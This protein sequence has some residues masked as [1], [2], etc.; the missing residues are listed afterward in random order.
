MLHK[1]IKGY[2]VVQHKFMPSDGLYWILANRRLGPETYEWLVAG[3]RHIDDDHW[4]TN[5][6]Y[7]IW[8]KDAIQ[9]FT[10][11]TTGF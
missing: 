3:L 9:R 4:V 8:Y 2:T 6:N 10:D 5:G 7:T 1:V 11:E